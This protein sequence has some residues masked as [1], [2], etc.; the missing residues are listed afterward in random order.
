ML[1]LLT[2]IKGG[3]MRNIDPVTPCELLKAEF[4]EPM[5]VTQYRLAKEIGFPAHRIGENVAGNPSITANA[6][7]RLCRF[8]GLSNSYWLRAQVV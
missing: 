6:D 5:R 4:L 3:F 8:F 1:Q 7:L 2:T